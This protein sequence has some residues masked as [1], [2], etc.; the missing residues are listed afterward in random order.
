MK[1]RQYFLF[2]V[3]FLSACL[4]VV[5]SADARSH[6]GFKKNVISKKLGD[7]KLDEA[8]TLK[9]YR[10][11]LSRDKVRTEEV[12]G[13]RH[14]ILRMDLQSLWK[15]DTR[16]KEYKEF[17]FMRLQALSGQQDIMRGQIQPLVEHGIFTARRDFYRTTNTMQDI[18]KVFMRQM[19]EKQLKVA[20]KN[21]GAQMDR[22]NKKPPEKKPVVTKVT[23]KYETIL[24]Y[25][26]RRID[27]LEG[28]DI[29]VSAW[30]T[31]DI[32]LGK[33]FMTKLQYLENFQDSVAKEI[34]KIKGFPMKLYYRTD[35]FLEGSD[36]ISQRGILE[37]V[38]EISPGEAFN[39]SV[40]ELPQGYSKTV[41]N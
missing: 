39:D 7:I 9:V 40:F 26:C 37:Q 29:L 20:L 41:S 1:V 32:E 23:D 34:K 38:T 8:G 35:V 31:N 15:V 4:L 14:T 11:Y 17:S 30:I 13:E 5:T 19:M 3:F 28:N 33:N 18:T 12:G 2:A 21:I 25:K 24:G 10:V 22:G 16:H 36:I 6:L 27:I